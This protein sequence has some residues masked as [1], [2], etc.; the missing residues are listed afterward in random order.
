MDI[1][2]TSKKYAKGAIVGGVALAVFA[3]IT[4]RSILG[5]GVIGAIAGGFITHKL[6]DE[7]INS[8]EKKSYK[9]ALDS[10]T[11]DQQDE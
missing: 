1:Q 8:V 6:S 9:K 5:W 3:A 7:K 2:E 10:D 4:R 11:V